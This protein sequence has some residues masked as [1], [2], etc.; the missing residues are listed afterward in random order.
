MICAAVK[1][2][3]SSICQ[4]KADKVVATV[5]KEEIRRIR[6]SH[7]SQSRHPFLRFFTGFVLV[8]TG[9]IMLMAAFIIAEGGVYLLQIQ[10][11]TLGIPIIPIVLWSMVGAGLWLLIGVFRGRY[12]LLLD[13]EKGTRKI[14]FAASADICEIQR[15]IERANGELGYDIDTSIMETMYFKPVP[16]NNKK[17]V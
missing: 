10:S 9:L 17:S 6:L 4:M 12:N 2:T 7:D 8:T 13:T 1:I 11:Y 3:E 14:F 16:G 5:P 15:F